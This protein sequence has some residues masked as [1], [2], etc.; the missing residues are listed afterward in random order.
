[1]LF[2]DGI[3]ILKGWAEDARRL[4]VEAETPDL[5]I[6]ATCTI[7][8]IKDAHIAF[9]ILGSDYFELSLVGCKLNFGDAEE[10]TKRM[11]IG[12]TAESAVIAMRDGLKLTVV[13][14]E[15]GS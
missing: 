7:Y 5:R 11:P 4:R 12:E 15:P 3:L 13:L 10:S 14:L 9:H 8:T 2:A 6:V 1:M